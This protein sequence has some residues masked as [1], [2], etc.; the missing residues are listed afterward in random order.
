LSS[1][2]VPADAPLVSVIIPAFNAAAFLGEAV[3]S[4][5]AQAPG[6][7]EIVPLEIVPLEIIIIDDGSSDR[8]PEVIGALGA[9]V[10]AL[11]QPN[12][13][14]AAARNLGLAGA[15]GEFIAFLDADDRWTQGKLE[16][17]LRKLRAEPAADLVVGATQRVRAAGAD[18]RLEPA[19]PV[20]MLFHLGAGLFRRRAFERVGAFDESLRQ[21]EDVDWFL[22]AREAGLNI[23]I[24][25]EV[26]QLYRV[27]GD[28][29]TH[30]QADRDRYFLAAMKKSLDRRRRDGRPAPELPPVEGLAGFTPGKQGKR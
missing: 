26:V 3:A 15:G 16:L 8:T 17:Q 22:R 29:M 9:G 28:N 4:V 23:A 13:G 12:R 18:G 25:S 14:P 24:V 2:T 6:P 7:L 30:N 1:R 21:G 11:H 5:R 10:R 19:G 20:W 27:H